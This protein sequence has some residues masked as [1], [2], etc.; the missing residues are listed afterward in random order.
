MRQKFKGLKTVTEAA[1]AVRK[2]GVVEERSIVGRRVT[3]RTP[4]RD[5]SDY[6]GT[7]SDKISEN[8]IRRKPKVSWG[9]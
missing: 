6:A 4:G 3:E 8:L 5:G 7:S 2:D 1:N 9:R